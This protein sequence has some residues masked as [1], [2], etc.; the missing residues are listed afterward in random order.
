MKLHKKA[1]TCQT[2]TGMKTGKTSHIDH[3]KFNSISMGKAQNEY[4]TV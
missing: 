4:I 1:S 2:R 3:Y